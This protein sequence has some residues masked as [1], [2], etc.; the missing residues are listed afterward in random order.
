MLD[1]RAI[2]ARATNADIGRMKRHGRDPNGRPR[3][4]ALPFSWSTVTPSSLA[5]YPCG[6]FRH[7]NINSDT[8]SA[9][10]RILRRG[11]PNRRAVAET[12]GTGMP[13]LNAM[14][15]IG[16]PAAHCPK[17]LVFWVSVRMC[18]DIMSARTLR[19]HAPSKNQWHERDAGRI[20]SK[21]PT[22]ARL[23]AKRSWPLS[24]C[25]ESGPCRLTI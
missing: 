9:D 14:A 10:H 17:N 7:E 23:H 8:I 2:H 22:A 5:K 24:L 15:L 11:N 16:T 20:H 6:I 13:K 25:K 1:R 18:G 21:P 19:F 12:F 4:R 3:R